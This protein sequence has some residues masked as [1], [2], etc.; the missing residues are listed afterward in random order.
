MPDVC[1]L[2]FQEAATRLAAMD[3]T[4]RPPDGNLD[5]QGR[6]TGSVP[7]AG[8]LFTAYGG[9]D[10][11]EVVVTLAAAPSAGPSC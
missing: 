4:L 6:V 5:P 7:A 1:G 3:I 10:A 9:K 2:T 11:R 8:Q